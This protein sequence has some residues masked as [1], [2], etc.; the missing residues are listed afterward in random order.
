MRTVARSHFGSP[1]RSRPETSVRSTPRSGFTV[2]TNVRV[3]RRFS[4]S[5]R[6]GRS[7]RA[8][9]G[10]LLSSKTGVGVAACPCGRGVLAVNETR[11]AGV[12]VCGLQQQGE[13]WL[14]SWRWLS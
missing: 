3:L 10:A 9:S 2:G 12:E 7:S 13:R 4:P 11:K 14:R 6:S 5:V 1:S 8:V